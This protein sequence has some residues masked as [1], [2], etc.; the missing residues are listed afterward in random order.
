MQREAAESLGRL[1]RSADADAA[2]ASL[3]SLERAL[4][5]K[6]SNLRRQVVESLGGLRRIANEVIPIVA[7]AV[8]DPDPKVQ[9]EAAEA[10]GHLSAGG[11]RASTVI[12]GALE[13][14]KAV[15]ENIR[16]QMREFSAKLATDFPGHNFGFSWETPHKRLPQNEGAD[17]R[18]DRE[19]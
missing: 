16:E 5:H 17:D 11:F 19:E 6:D 4:S 2:R 15:V 7:K 12:F 10:L 1:L 14:S 9:R 3:P 13:D 8:D 18:E